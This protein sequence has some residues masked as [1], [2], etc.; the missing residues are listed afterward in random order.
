MDR[1]P[2]YRKLLTKDLF[3]EGNPSLTSNNRSYLGKCKIVMNEMLDVAFSQNNIA[4]AKS[5]CLLKMTVTER[6][7]V[8]SEC[9]RELNVAWA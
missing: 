8:F 9:F 3:I 6:D 4:C 1:V 7:K 5:T 2:P